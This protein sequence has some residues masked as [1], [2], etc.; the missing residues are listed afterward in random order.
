MQHR[1]DR[2]QA[3]EQYENLDG[4][5]R[6]RIADATR[7]HLSIALAHERTR[8]RQRT[9]FFGTPSTQILSSR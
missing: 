4:R 7:S 9:N 3:Q 5:D 1:G 2:E 6:E 8:H